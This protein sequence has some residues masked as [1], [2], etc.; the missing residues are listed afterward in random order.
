MSREITLQLDK[1]SKMFKNMIDWSSGEEHF[2]TS[3]EAKRM[4][5]DML[6]AAGIKYLH[7]IIP[8]T[9]YPNAEQG[10]DID[11]E[12]LVL[13]HTIN[14]GLLKVHSDRS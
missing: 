13:F 7:T 2:R 9:K 3:M 6:H 10:W 11:K 8:N 5:E 4:A 1:T 12:D 14:T